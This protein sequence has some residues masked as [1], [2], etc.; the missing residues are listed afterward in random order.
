MFKKPNKGNKTSF[1][2]ALILLLSLSGLM[3]FLPAVSAHNPSWT[4][5]TYSFVN[6]ATNPVGVNQPLE[7]A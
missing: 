5:P 1:A 6:A 3:A 2:V 7:I 4:I